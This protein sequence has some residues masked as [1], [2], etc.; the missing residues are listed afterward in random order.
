MYSYSS[1]PAFAMLLLACCSWYILFMHLHIYV[2]V[3]RPHK[4][5]TRAYDGL[6]GNYTKARTCTPSYKVSHRERE[7]KKRRKRKQFVW[8]SSVWHKIAREWKYQCTWKNCISSEVLKHFCLFFFYELLVW[9]CIITILCV[10]K[11]L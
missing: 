10:L 2:Y 11:Q 3:Y 9:I 8:F 4:F 1:A 5:P 6:V 7:R